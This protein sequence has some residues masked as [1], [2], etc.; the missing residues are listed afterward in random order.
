MI[1]GSDV[2]LILEDVRFTDRFLLLF[3]FLQAVKNI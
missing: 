2:F 1:R 3:Y